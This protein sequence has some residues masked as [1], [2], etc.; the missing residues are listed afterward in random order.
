[1]H[2]DGK[3]TCHFASIILNRLKYYLQKHVPVNHCLAQMQNVNKVSQLLPMHGGLTTA[4]ITQTGEFRLQSTA[5]CVTPSII[6]TFSGAQHTACPPPTG[7]R[8]VVPSIQGPILVS[9]FA[10]LVGR[11]A[12]PRNKSGNMIVR[13][14]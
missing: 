5:H 6:T 14:V 11:P 1:M 13:D 8:S 7:G 10:V 3:F 2:N 9:A 12:R 4:A